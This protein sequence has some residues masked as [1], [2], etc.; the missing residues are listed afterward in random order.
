M[1]FVRVKEVASEATPA[2]PLQE[3]AKL[4][5]GHLSPDLSLGPA[6]SSDKA[7]LG[8]HHKSLAGQG[9]A[10]RKT[11]GKEQKSMRYAVFT[12]RGR[13]AKQT[14]RL[15]QPWLS[16]E[17]EIKKIE[18]IAEYRLYASRGLLLSNELT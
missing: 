17:N 16:K 11:W 8:G 5:R 2:T 15:T 1:R 18:N 9:A 14:S 3:Q 4:D 12:T 13:G 10:Y 6:L 7:R